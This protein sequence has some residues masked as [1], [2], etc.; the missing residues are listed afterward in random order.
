MS[1]LAP[2][3]DA[4]GESG[5][6]GAGEAAE[7]L[8]P[9]EEEVPPEVRGRWRDTGLIAFVETRRFSSITLCHGS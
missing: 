7:E 4:G 9:E 2:V 8:K 1:E 5:E 6:V 3:D